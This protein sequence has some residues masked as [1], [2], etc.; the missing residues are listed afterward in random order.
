MVSR[1]PCQI[2]FFEDFEYWNKRTA[3]L[4]A[5]ERN[6]REMTGL[7]PDPKLVLPSG[8]QMFHFHCSIDFDLARAY[9][10]KLLT[11]PPGESI[12]LFHLYVVL[13][14]VGK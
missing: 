14:Y 8:L 10:F 5:W 7:V 13:P 3:N 1:Y 9:K 12:V 4:T 11:A 6:A 2:T